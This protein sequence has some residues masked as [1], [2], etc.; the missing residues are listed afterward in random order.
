MASLNMSSWWIIDWFVMC[1]PMASSM[2][3]CARRRALCR[4]SST[5]SAGGFE[6]LLMMKFMDRVIS[7]P[8]TAERK[9]SIWEITLAPQEDNAAGWVRKHTVSFDVAELCTLCFSWKLQGEQ[10]ILRTI[11]VKNP[12]RIRITKLIKSIVHSHVWPSNCFRLHLIM[13]I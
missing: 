6:H 3:T 4:L 5:T 8:R 1:R 10:G 2:M 12:R 13:L 9:L 7:S 11:R